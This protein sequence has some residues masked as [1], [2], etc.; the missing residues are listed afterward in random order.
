MRNGTNRVDFINFSTADAKFSSQMLK[1][2]LVLP[3]YKQN[4]SAYQEPQEAQEANNTQYGGC[5]E[6]S[7]KKHG[8][9]SD[10]RWLL[11]C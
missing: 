11:I 9:A 10:R 8:L 2:A 3:D 5:I 6:E 4:P 7:L 1:Q